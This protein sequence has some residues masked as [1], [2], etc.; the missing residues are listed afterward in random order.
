MNRFRSQI[1]ELFSGLR[2]LLSAFCFLLSVFC[3][4]LSVSG[5]ATTRYRFVGI[6]N[7]NPK[8][9]LV[10]RIF[11]ALGKLATTTTLYFFATEIAW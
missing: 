3:F 2:F 9:A 6:K 8:D 10:Q 5:P 7:E 1:F 4:L 11:E